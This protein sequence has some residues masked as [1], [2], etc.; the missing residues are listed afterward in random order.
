M[1]KDSSITSFRRKDGNNCNKLD[2]NGRISVWRLTIRNKFKTVSIFKTQHYQDTSFVQ[3]KINLGKEILQIQENSKWHSL[4]EPPVLLLK[5]VVVLIPLYTIKMPDPGQHFFCYSWNL[6]LKFYTLIPG[7]VWR[8]PALSELHIL[9]CPALN[10][11][12]SQE[13]S[14]LLLQ[15]QRLSTMIWMKKE[16][17]PHRHSQP[18]DFHPEFILRNAVTCSNP[19]V[20]G[21]R[22]FTHKKKIQTSEPEHYLIN[23]FTPSQ[24]SNSYPLIS[25]SKM[26]LT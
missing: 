3:Y 11:T 8:C 15:K 20:V 9:V 14:K 22:C 17:T 16:V 23:I 10:R 25:V 2:F 18:Y 6:F 4:R 24:A 5:A 13:C 12:F 19:P 26:K 1:I 7:M 21:E